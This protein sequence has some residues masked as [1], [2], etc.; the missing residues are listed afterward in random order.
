VLYEKEILT[1]DLFETMEKIC[2][3][4]NIIVHHY[5]RIEPEIVVSILR[6]DIDDFLEFKNVIVNLLSQ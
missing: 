2:K 3:F 6:K 1:K 4:R 5:D